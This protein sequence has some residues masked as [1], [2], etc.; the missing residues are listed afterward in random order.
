MGKIWL[1]PDVPVPTPA[2]VKPEECHNSHPG[3]AHNGGGWML[4][5]T[6]DGV[7]PCC[8]WRESEP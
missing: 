6:P 4:P 8:G 7:C 2:L 1:P 5:F 3:N